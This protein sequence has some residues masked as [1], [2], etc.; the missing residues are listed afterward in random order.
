MERTNNNNYT[1]VS[2]VWAG[3]SELE[4]T[5]SSSSAGNGF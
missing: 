4:V 2:G 3:T 5:G 1:E